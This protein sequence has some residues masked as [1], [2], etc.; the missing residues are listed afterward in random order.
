MRILHYK[1]HHFLRGQDY[2]R[3]E[4]TFKLILETNRC[5]FREPQFKVYSRTHFTI[6]R[7]TQG[8][9]VPPGPKVADRRVQAAL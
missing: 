4:E 3:V 8:T 9:V 2:A 6:P 5:R 1:R 7:L